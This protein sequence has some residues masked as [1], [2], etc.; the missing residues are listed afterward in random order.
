MTTAI[1]TYAAYIGATPLSVRADSGGSIT[2]DASRA[3]HVQGDLVIAR[4]SAATLA[5]LDPRSSIVPR[6]VVTASAG[7]PRTFDL[8]VRD[9][10]I[11]HLG[12]LVSL[13]L[14]SD[15]GLLEDYAPLEDDRTPRQHEASLRAVV[16]YVLNKAIPGA[17]LEASPAN[18]ANVT[19]YWAVTN[20]LANP[21]VEAA[22]APWTNGGNCSLFHASVGR[23]GTT[24]CGFNSSAAGLLAVMPHALNSGPNVTPGKSYVLAAHA[25]Q[26]Q[27]S[28]SRSIRAGIRWLNAANMPVG[29]DVEGAWVP[30][31]STDWTARPYVIATA[32]PGASKAETFWRV[33]GTTAAGQIGYVDDAM[34]Y[35]GNELIPAFNG[36][37]V[38]SSTYTYG[39]A[40]T[41][42]A[43]ASTRTPVL[44]RS[45]DALIWRAGQT[46]MAFLHSL[47]QAN[48]LRLVC[49]EQRKWTLRGELYQAP[50]AL[51]LRH[52]V[53]V[54]D[55][56]EK[57]SRGAGFWYDA[58]V[59]RYKWVDL[60]GI[61]QERVDAYAL[62]TPY[63]RLTLVD[64]D[65]AYP[66]PGRSEYAVRRA[67]GVGREVTVETVSD[68][69][70]RAEQP[71]SILLDGAPLQ[72]ANTQS[73]TFDFTTDRMTISART[74]EIGARSINAL[75]GTINAL[76]GTI[77]N[78]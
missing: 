50:G 30:M 36:S 14:A 38:A 25:Q 55:A 27:A 77:N 7:I 67:Q 3:P 41:A 44:E 32:P 45:P 20:L 10:G 17:T 56:D 28:P 8:H 52:A 74:V 42:H 33:T 53:N 47:I 40:G 12:A 6:V 18:D 71:A 58:R 15:E 60:D 46:A 31:T 19:A 49:D 70:A 29:P 66:G 34:F 26:Y 9:L 39:W 37:T 65:A 61:P 73:V 23:T 43:S 78:L 69:T 64:V 5:A 62:T 54:I 22:L 11:T 75:T 2:L 1:H 16:G 63:T 76:T 72:A 4:P 59:T 51:T 13:T 57:I 48:G 68:W 21:T 35:E 24:S